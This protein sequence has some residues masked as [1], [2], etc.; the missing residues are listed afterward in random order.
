MMEEAKH[1]I[2][3][4]DSI[5][6]KGSLRSV[7]KVSLKSLKENQEIRKNLGGDNYHYEQC[8]GVPDSLDSSHFLHPQCLKKITYAKTL[9][10]RKGREEN[11]STN[12]FKS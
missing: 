3:H 10:K 9:A 4:Y 12:K 11:P 5:Q 8:L 2:I 1:C 7:T 6:V